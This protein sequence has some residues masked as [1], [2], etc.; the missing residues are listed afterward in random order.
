MVL[1]LLYGSNVLLICVMMCGVG[2][3]LLR[4]NMRLLKVLFM[5]NVVEIVFVFIY[6]M[7]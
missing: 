2:M 4:D 5:W 3:L 7:L 6:I 1:S